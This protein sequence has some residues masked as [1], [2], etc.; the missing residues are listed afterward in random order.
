MITLYSGWNHV[1]HVLHSDPSVMV[2]IDWK[3]KGCL[4]ERIARVGKS[5]HL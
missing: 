5:P 3:M 1:V 2:K 4:L